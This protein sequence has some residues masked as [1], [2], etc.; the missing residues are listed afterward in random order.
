MHFLPAT[1]RIQLHLGSRHPFPVFACLTKLR[2]HHEVPKKTT[3]Q[4]IIEQAR[5]DPLSLS[6]DS[7]QRRGKRAIQAPRPPPFAKQSGIFHCLESQSIEIPFTRQ[8]SPQHRTGP[9]STGISRKPGAPLGTLSALSTF[10]N[11]KQ[12]IPIKATRKAQ[13]A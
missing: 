13:S 2:A 4:A 8:Q 11:P 12:L 1:S 3:R 7:F 9:F 10:P 6:H 5:Q